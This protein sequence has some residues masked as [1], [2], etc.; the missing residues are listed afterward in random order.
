MK[1][2]RIT[3]IIIGVLILAIAGLYYIAF[4]KTGVV[5]IPTLSVYE[6]SNNVSN[7]T[8][9]DTV[10]YESL[11]VYDG[12]KV[13]NKV[14]ASGYKVPNGTASQALTADGGTATFTSVDIASEKSRVVTTSGWTFNGSLLRI[15]KFIYLSGYFQSPSGYTHSAEGEVQVATLYNVVT[16]GVGYGTASAFTKTNVIS[17]LTVQPDNAIKVWLPAISSYSGYTVIYGTLMF[18]ATT[19]SPV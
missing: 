14:L 10:R 11:R 9:F 2:I 5:D 18:A 12:V 6:R 8:P 13:D 1:K 19:V 3:N 17:Y 7:A 16:N 15:N 4:H